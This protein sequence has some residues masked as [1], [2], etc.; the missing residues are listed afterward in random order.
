MKQSRIEDVLPLGPLQEGLLFHAQYDTQGLDLYTVQSVFHLGADFDADAMRLA[1]RALQQRHAVLR[2]GFRRQG[3]RPVQVI[4]REVPL[5]WEEE[6]LSALAADERGAALRRILDEDRA[7]KFDM[8]RPPLM[9]FIHVKLGEDQHRLVMTRHHILMDGWSSPILIGELFALYAGRG[10]ASALPPVTPYREYLLWLSKQD[11]P[12]AE[13]VWRTVLDGVTAPTLLVP[14]APSRVEVA[15]ENIIGSLPEELTAS[16]TRLARSRDWTM[17]TLVQGAWGLLLG[18][19]TGRNDVTFGT[20]VSGRPPEIP[21][22]ETMVGLFINTLPVRVRLDP[23]ESLGGIISRLQEQQIEVMDHQFLSLT[24]IQS[25]VG[26]GNLFDTATV[27]ENQFVDTE[28]L[29][30]STTGAQVS[31][32]SGRDATHYPLALAAG[33]GRELMLRLAYRPDLIDRATAE[34][35]LTQ[36]VRIF[37]TIAADPELPAGR[38]D[39]LDPVV[40]QQV[41]EEWN[42][43]ARD[44]PAGTLPQLFEAQVARTPDAVAVVQD[45][46]RLSYAELNARAN[47]MARYLIGHGV[48]PERLVALSLPRSVDWITAVLGVWKAGAAYLPVDPQYPADRVAHMLEDSAPALTLSAPVPEGELA[49]FAAG[50]V[51]DGER[52]ASLDGNHPAYV[53]YTSGSTGR[54]KGVVMVH[55]SAASMAATHIDTLGVGPHSRVF[56]AVSTN[57]DPSVGDVLMAL[58]SGA[59]LALPHGQLVGDELAAALEEQAATHV[60]MSA[61]LLATLPA[62]SLPRLETIVSGGEVCPPEVIARWSAGRRLINAYG[63]TEA[64]VVSTFS[65]PLTAGGGVPPIGGP[66]ANTRAYVLDSALRPV[67]PGVAGDL[68]LAGG[69]LARGYLR[70]AGQTAE[71]FVADPYGA[72]GERMYATGDVARWRAD[73]VLEF[74]GRSDEQV[75]I[76]GFRIELGEV[77]A[78]LS[79]LPGVGQAAVTVREDRPGDRRLVG[80]AVPADGRPLSVAELRSGAA[81][82]LPDHMVPGAFVLLDRLPL[83]PNGKLDKK[84]LPAPDLTSLTAGRSAQTPQEEILCGLFA[85]VLKLPRVGAEGNF[86][87]LGGHSLLATRLVSRIRSTL[88]AELEIRELFEHPTPAALAGRLDTA[89]AARKALVPQPRPEVVPLSFAQRRQWIINRFEEHAASYNIPFLVRLAGDLDR[90]ALRAALTD[91]AG[92]HETLRTVFPEADGKPLRTP[93]DLPADGA[94]LT[95]VETDEAS[96]PA[97][98][99]AEVGR[100]FDL[101]TDLPFR[102][103]LFD[104]AGTGEVVLSLVLHHVAA[105]GWSMAPLARDLSVAYAARLR[106][107]APQWSPLPVQYA[108]FALWQQDVL[109]S[110]DDPQSAIS[111][112][113]AFWKESLAQLPEDLKLPVDRNRPA[114][115]T[116]RGDTLEIRL[117]AALHHELTLLARG[118]HASVFM[119][120]QAAIALLLSRLGAGED[121]VLGT[122]VAGRTDEALD[123]LVGFFVNT[124]VLRTDVSGDP[125]FRE[126]V[127]R[128]REG[129]LAAYAHQDV[130][131][132][133]LVE[134]LNPERSLARHPL[135]QTMLSMQNNVEPEVDLPGLDVVPQ[136]IDT[137]T[138]KFDLCFELAEQFAADGSADGILGIIR[139]STDLFDRQSVARI[140]DRLGQLLAAVATTPDAPSSTIEILGAAERG[141]VLEEWNDTAVPVTTGSLPELFEAQVRRTP[142]R[143]AVVSALSVGTEMTYAQ[144]NARANRLARLLIDEGVGPEQ[145]V[146]VALPRTAQLFVAVLAVLKAGAAYVPVDPGY[147]AERIAFMLADAA[148]AAVLTTTD[149]IPADLTAAIPRI[150]LDDAAVGARTAALADTDPAPSERHALLHADCPAYVIYT[151]GSTGTPKGVIATHRD[152]AHLALD[153]CWRGGNH[154]RVLLHSPHAFDA[155]TYEMWTPLLNG[156]Q[157]VM[158]P[159]GDFDADVLR[160]ALDEGKASALFITSGLFSLMAKEAPG[161]F[162]HVREV[163]AGGDVVSP[164]A[165]RALLTAHPD[166]TVVNGYGPTETTTFAISHR[167]TEPPEAGQVLPIGRPLDNTR[168]YVLDDALRPVPVGVEGELYIGGAGLARGYL[169]R[170]ALTGERFVADPFG[171]AGARMYRTGDRARWN[172]RG[173]VEFLGRA[174]DQVK[175]RGFRIELGEIE[176][177]LARHAAVHQAVAIV[178]EDTPGDQR[179]VAY[180]TRRPDVTAEAGELRRYL[181]ESLPEYMVPSAVVVLAE[182]PLT[183]NG[184]V[185]RRALPLPVFGGDSSRRG[186]STPREETLCKLF[187]EALGLPQVWMDD[188]FFDLGGHSLL[189]TELAARIRVAFGVELTIRSLFE[190]PTVA[191]LVE[192]MDHGSDGDPL[193]VML[194]LRSRGDLPPLFC[195]HSGMGASWDYY[196]LLR[197]IEPDR[198]VYGLQARGL[199]QRENLPR[200][201]E[202]M[203]DDYL[204]QIKAIQPE[205]PYHLLGWSFGGVAAHAMATKLQAA[206]EE[207]AL[208]AMLDSYPAENDYDAD[209]RAGLGTEHEWLLG[210]LEGAGITAYEGPVDAATVSVL[211]RESGM[212]LGALDKDQLESMYVAYNNIN[213]IFREYVPGVYQ[214]SVLYFF[215]ALDRGEMP[216]DVTSW[217]PYVAQPLDVVRMDCNH[218]QMTQ[219]GPIGEVGRALTARLRSLH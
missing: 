188:N 189:A 174:D 2:A 26:L 10:D 204:D 30:S 106:A 109:G 187:A 62:V 168:T 206:G 156:G 151:S 210:L 186:A 194:P 129:D 51:T 13:R 99:A 73:G 61:S 148:P 162:A 42:D 4:R 181:T 49:A 1:A 184:K 72:P 32:G 183:A 161:S 152:V 159:P 24:E 96:L 6:D 117:D 52:V 145:Y 193:E 34:G 215:A 164:T 160:A 57:F 219:P 92:R 196:G 78:V 69:Q 89:A 207:V 47:R 135:F 113:L 67:A 116:F 175:L 173:C 108:D 200:T 107:Q 197:H 126:L 56:Q 190:A 217:D 28:T 122:P 71:R 58:L 166:L 9:R 66:V 123:D 19:L 195:V 88:G 83:T 180:V 165:V 169:N 205:G 176:T 3:E 128:V 114:V 90:D 65:E 172:A 50:N 53:I 46:D 5:R 91:V 43:T 154:D 125:T 100:G 115:S 93:A 199:T 79:A 11:R 85:E 37:E 76:R 170:R 94:D 119:V 202:E 14:D 182:L 209:M 81:R 146:A 149:G 39:L 29:E 41:L 101:L 112:Q 118:A 185:D 33:P 216:P 130:P 214:G 7:R 142:E 139:Y 8:A 21:G 68:Y 192:R 150:V 179:L 163:W 87:E 36:L 55:R 218:G 153:S 84:A 18:A 40:R 103:T 132:E 17:N 177:A 80:Y 86:F 70:R 64:A 136:P 212:A 22:I 44:I 157:S 203:A 167:I 133:R 198:P 15:P 48:G 23:A 35:Y 147:P 155:S 127:A 95:V 31:G 110:E 171:A 74:V 105:D 144:L 45:D 38:V 211:L 141:Q 178:R 27:F 140:G 158:L 208:L 54:P 137:G 75:K 120:V 138:S 25:G 102:A 131:F 16:L 63:P 121:I 213:T 201:L 82:Q 20:T 77:E 97:A 111:R 143:T 12:A 104:L 191:R 98:L 124:L 134:I 59:S 60:M